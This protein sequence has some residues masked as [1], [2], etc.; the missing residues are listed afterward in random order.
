MTMDDFWRLPLSPFPHLFFPSSLLAN[1][2]PL[3][4]HPGGPWDDPGTHSGAQERRPWGPDFDF[5]WFLVDIGIQFWEP[6]DQS[7][8]LF[9]CLFPGHFSD[10]SGR[11]IRTSGASKASIWCGRGCKNEL[12][13]EV[14]IMLIS[15]S[16]FDDFGVWIWTVWCAKPIICYA[17]CLHFA[18]WG[19]MGR[20]RGT[21]EH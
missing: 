12:S 4:W 5:Y 8:C 16:T 20:S 13:T 11:W 1:L 21:S 18:P 17:F 7:R 6:W 14:G 10:G 2:L 15:M 19:T 9:A 3:L